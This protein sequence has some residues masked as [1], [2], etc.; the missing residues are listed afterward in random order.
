MGEW[1]AASQ[2]NPFYTTAF[3]SFEALG[4]AMRGLITIDNEGNWKADLGTEVPSADN[5]GLVLADGG[6]G[7]TVNVSLKPGLLWSDGEPLTMNDF[8]YTYDRAVQDAI[9]GAGCAGCASFVPL[10]DPSIGADTDG[11]DG[12]IVAD[13]A[14]TYAADNQYVESI[15]VSDDGASAAIVWKTNYAGW[16]G[17]VSTAPLPEHYFADIPTADSATAMPV[18]PGIENVPWSGPFKI[19]S[20]SSEGIDYERNDNWKA[21]DP[22]WLDGLRF[23]YYGD[24]AGMQT[25]FLN[26][27]IDIALDMTQADFAAIE[28]VDPG[29]GVAKL[30]SVWQYEHLDLNVSHADVGLAEPDV[31]KAIAMA[32]DKQDLS[33][34]LFPNA[35]V[36]PACSPAPPGTYWRIET[37]CPAFNVEGAN[38][39]L[40]TAGWLVND[41]PDT[42]T[43]LREKDVDG[44][45]TNEQ[46]RL[47]LC[48]SSGNPTRLT[49]MGKINQYLAA[50]GIPSDIQTADAGSV[51]FAGW[52][53]TT[54]KTECSIYRGT[55]DVA[56]FAYILG[57]DLYSNYYYTYHSSQIPS[58]ANPNGSNDTR[59]NDP[60]LDAAL[61]DLGTLVDLDEQLAAAATVQTAYAA[62]IAEI[63]LYYRGEVTGIGNHVGGWLNYNPSSAGPTWDPEVW[64]FI[65]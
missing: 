15:T 47:K 41:D 8:K 25:A 38:A 63:P 42:G 49:T 16:L 35:G 39:L 30:D 46:L 9:G 53:D 20:A 54:A 48:T 45:G 10:I 22:A 19:V 28:G 34:V 61:D 14:A 23:R 12:P 57:G 24:K 59:I 18:G 31:R 7:F 21:G 6:D 17:W 50:V 1:Q 4:P 26:G 43:G 32:I 27:E 51:Y 3:T 2:L 36:E 37:E 62:A 29:V 64:Y 33:N 13:L 52:A 40:D 58:D 11:P 44:D 60:E 56:L 65:P 5:G 55:Y